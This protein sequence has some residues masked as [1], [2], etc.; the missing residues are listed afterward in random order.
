MSYEENLMF[1]LD[2][3]KALNTHIMFVRRSSSFYRVSLSEVCFY[4]S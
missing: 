3:K 1:L 2:F 4:M